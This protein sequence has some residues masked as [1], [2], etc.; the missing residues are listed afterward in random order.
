M[1]KKIARI[2]AWQSQRLLRASQARVIVVAGSIGKT[3]TTQAIAT[4]LSESFQVR[5]TI[6]NYNTDIGV[7]CSLF[8]RNIP[9][10]L[11]DPLRWLHIFFQNEIAIARERR[12]SSFNVA[13]LELGTDM[14]G[15][16]NQ[17]SWIEPEV[18]VITAIAPE[19]MEVFK[20]LDAVAKEEL[21]VLT[22]AKV[23]LINGSR[24]DEKYRADLS[25]PYEVY[26]HDALEGIIKQ[27]ALQVH[28]AH[29]IDAISAAIRVANYL[30]MSQASIKTGVMNIK[31][32]PGRMNI[33]RGLS[34]SV[35]IDDTYNASP[36]AVQAAIRY[37][38]DRKEKYKVAVL[39]NMNEL[40]ET[41]T[42]EHTLIGEMCDPKKVNLVV[43]LGSDAN[44]YTAAAA[45]KNGCE[46]IEATSPYEAAKHV[47]TFLE[48]HKDKTCVL[49]K[50][51]QNGVFA[52][53]TVKML[54]K[55]ETDYKELVRQS[56]SWL[57][58]KKKAFEESQ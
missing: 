16:L 41:S 20:T 37:L 55:N 34:D 13:V 36:E 22:Y 23:G 14:I 4:V 50:G 8:Q 28:G 29:S 21:S 26:G 19:H 7:P 56:E 6:A 38:Y 33:L 12:N 40:G 53:E 45:R 11:S 39:G 52:E 2:L 54:L 32:Q 44:N 17:F 15:E 18:A 9:R 58:K 3:S 25:I 51:S 27:E 46:V 24:V 35:I 48:S 47:K 10:S 5:K 49:C 30:K 43:T 1:R 57:A 42:T 31:P